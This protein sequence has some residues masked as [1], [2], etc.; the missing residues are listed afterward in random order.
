M[1]Y[2]DLKQ[3]YRLDRMKEICGHVSW[4][5]NHLYVKY[6]FKTRSLDSRMAIACWIY[7]RITMTFLIKFD[8][9]HIVT[10]R[11]IFT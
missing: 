2:H 5:L 3:H 10:R 8:F 11:T 1:M 4:C 6:E 9:E 7:E